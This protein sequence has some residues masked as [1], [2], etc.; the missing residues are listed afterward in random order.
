MQDW[1]LQK[2]RAVSVFSI[3]CTFFV[4]LKTLHLLYASSEKCLQPLGHSERKYMGN[5]N[6]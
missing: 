2:L 3:L 6:I 4:S 5:Y 1:S